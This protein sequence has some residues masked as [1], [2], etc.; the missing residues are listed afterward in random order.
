MTTMKDIAKKANVALATVSAVINQSAYVSPEL[1]KRVMQVIEELN[2]K[3]NAVARSLKKKSTNTI[4]VIVT[5]ISNP[6]YPTMIKGMDDVAIHNNFN[7]I[8][9]NTSN[10][11]KRFLTY[12]N[13]MVEKQVDGLLLANISK[14]EDL[15][16]VEKTGL[17]YVL[18][19]RKPS[20]YGKNFVGIN[21]LLTSEL[22]VNHLA[23]QGY[24]RIA[25]FGGDSE[26]STAR[27]RKAG[28]FNGMNENRLEV[29]PELIFDGDYSL[30]S[31]YAN[32]INMLNQVKE[33]P[34]AICASSDVIGFGIVKGLRDSGLRVPEDIVVMGN[35]NNPFSENFIVPLSTVDHPTYDMGRLSMDYLLQ[36]VNEKDEVA[37]KQIILTPSL[38]VRESCGFTRKK[39]EK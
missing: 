24:K 15:K 9:C 4:G 13:L 32:V 19:N 35:D 2:Y 34:E 3:P 6:Y 30:E 20:S 17:K 7:V 12:L 21:N 10:D 39:L 11:D 38:V 23:E 29:D 5:D 37:N 31:G 8:L 33:L 1:T 28:F 16:E 36:M 26:I 27:E 25:Y 18:V 22:A 14:T